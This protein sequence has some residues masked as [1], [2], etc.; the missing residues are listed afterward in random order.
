MGKIKG[1]PAF[2]PI[3]CFEKSGRRPGDIDLV[4]KILNPP[5]INRSS[6]GWSGVEE[7][8]YGQRG[9]DPREIVATR[10][11]PRTRNSCPSARHTSVLGQWTTGCRASMARL[12]GM[13]G[14][15]ADSSRGSDVGWNE[16]EFRYG[17]AHSPSMMARPLAIHARI[18]VDLVRYTSN[19][20]F[21]SAGLVFVDLYWLQ[22]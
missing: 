21:T 15:I 13:A 16:L 1:N 22:G 7:W 19:N 11:Q 9:R 14:R 4:A 5:G 10:A 18:S 3:A 8:G 20:N 12:R 2:E 17:Y 6:R